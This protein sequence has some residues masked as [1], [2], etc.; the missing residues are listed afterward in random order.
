MSFFARFRRFPE[1][2]TFVASLAALSK[3][4]ATITDGHTRAFNEEFR[5]Y[6]QSQKESFG[7]SLTSITDAGADQAKIE[8]ER[9]AAVQSLPQDLQPLLAQEAEIARWR[10]LF[11]SLNETAVKSRAAADRAD[12][13]VRSASGGA[14]PKAEQALSAARRKAETDESSAADQKA[15]LEK[16]EDPFRRQFLESFVTPLAK[17][18]DARYK[19]AEQLLELSEKFATAAQGLVEFE[20]PTIER[21]RNRLEALEK[22]VVE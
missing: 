14:R 7:T 3:A 4:E 2:H 21:F 20:D 19:S 9:I 16:K 15:A 10:E 11:N 17:T 12:A 18:I 13:A 6:A 5:R 8:R 22:I 1:F